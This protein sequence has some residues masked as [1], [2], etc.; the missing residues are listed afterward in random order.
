MMLI[1]YNSTYVNAH[2]ACGLLE[3]V[4]ITDE[5]KQ[6]L[7]IISDLIEGLKAEFNKFCIANKVKD[8]KDLIA[9]SKIDK[10]VKENLDKWM[11]DIYKR[12]NDTI[13]SMVKTFN[14][15]YNPSYKEYTTKVDK[16]KK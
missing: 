12:K 13:E 2:I 10:K 7:A 6:E 8:V 16:V 1:I 14:L 5:Q 11:S 3:D 9:K 4:K 15:K